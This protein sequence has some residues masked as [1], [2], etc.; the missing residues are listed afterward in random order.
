M[1][2]Q[3]EVDQSE[4]KKLRDLLVS[5]NYKMFMSFNQE[6]YPSLTSLVKFYMDK[7]GCIQDL[8]YIS[9]CFTVGGM[10]A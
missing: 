1:A 6:D 9:Q 4:E 10:A 3:A 2:L 8:K 5:L 7:Q